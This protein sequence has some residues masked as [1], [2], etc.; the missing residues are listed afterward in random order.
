MELQKMRDQIDQLNQDKK[1]MSESNE[2]LQK[3]ITG[4]RKELADMTAEK[5]KLEFSFEQSEKYGDYVNLQIRCKQLDQQVHDSAQQL[6]D[7]Q[8]KNKHITA[9]TK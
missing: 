4:L 5:H 7:A 3:Q 6:Q 1:N 2:S 8:L 9:L